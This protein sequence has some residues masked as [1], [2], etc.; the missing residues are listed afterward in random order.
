MKSAAYL[1]II[2]VAVHALALII[3]TFVAVP[4]PVE[5]G[6]DFIKL[7]HMK[8]IVSE[9]V[10]KN[11]IER[12][13]PK[14]IRKDE[15][16]SVEM[17][18]E[19]RL[20]V[21]VFTIHL[22]PDMT[23]RIRRTNIERIQGSKYDVVNPF[24]NYVNHGLVSELTKS[25]KANRRVLDK[26]IYEGREKPIAPE[27]QFEDLARF[28]NRSGHPGIKFGPLTGSSRGKEDA[29]R[30]VSAMFSISQRSA[31]SDFASILPAISE[32]ILKRLYSNQVDIVFIV[33]TTGSMQDNVKG[34][35]EHISLFIDPLQRERIDFAL[36]LVL[37]SDEEVK[38]AKVIG[39]TDDKGKFIKW[40]SK[41]NFY[42]GRDLAESG[43][44]AIVSALKGI[45]FRK[46]AQKS[47]LFISD[48]IQHDLDYDGKSNYTLDGIIS[49]LNEHK[50]S[51]DVI[52]LD[53]LPVK[54]LSWGTGGEWKPIP[55]GDIRFDLP[56]PV[57][58]RILSRPS[59]PT[60][61]DII[62]DNVIIKFDGKTPEWVDFYYK[63][64]D[65][66]GH[67]VIEA[68]GYRKEVG[69]HQDSI[70]FPVRIDFSKFWKEPGIYTLIYKAKDSHGKQ[71]ILRQTLQLTV[72][73]GGV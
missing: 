70:E 31:N 15:V 24:S 10:R 2:S 16:K 38:K 73:Q 69:E 60:R 13:E 23:N 45:D 11:E 17:E 61:S 14:S 25:P 30:Y 26:P 46:G 18:Q 44:E 43:F 28:P 72:E 52:G 27:V 57:P 36:G 53:Y 21:P 58:S 47:F 42:G 5:I 34:V 59:T 7:E 37:F 20:Q 63:V 64:L 66:K 62:E 40:L 51:V 1:L 12:Q 35:L 48:S 3:L 8:V 33:D 32:S 55:N 39:L 54:Q 19:R 9:T 22:T 41:V 4:R 49:L 6:H 68:V 56:P 50:V 65:P 71:D 29:S 67:K